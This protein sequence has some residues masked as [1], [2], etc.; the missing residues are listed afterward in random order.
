[1]HE[2]T[3]LDTKLARLENVHVAAME[4]D[5]KVVFLHKV[6]KGAADKSYGIYVADLAGLPTPLLARAK[7]LLQTFENKEKGPINEPQQMAFF[8]IREE[9][10]H[11]LS[12]EK[13]EVLASLE[14]TDLLNMTPLNALQYVFELKEKLRSA[15]G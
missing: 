13:K 6:M 9:E 10:Q 4:Q 14:E 3:M 12:D 1:Y 7:E 11:T 2:L 8:D 5:G 15:K